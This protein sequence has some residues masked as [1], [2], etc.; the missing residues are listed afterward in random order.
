MRLDA[1]RIASTHVGQ[2]ATYSPST[3]AANA[4]RH[5]STTTARES[6]CQPQTT[7]PTS[8]GNAARTSAAVR[9]EAEEEVAMEAS[10]ERVGVMFCPCCVWPAVPS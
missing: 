2:Q 7:G 9:F 6:I 10:E 8:R 4:S 3:S 5:C 1:A